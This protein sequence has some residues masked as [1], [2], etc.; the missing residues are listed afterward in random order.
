[1]QQFLFAHTT[2][3]DANELVDTCLR[4][5]GK[6]PDEATLG[7]IYASDALARELASIVARLRAKTG[8]THW[9]GSVGIA[10]NVTGHEYYD[11]PALAI[12][13]ADFPADSFTLLP[14]IAHEHALPTNTQQAHF[15]IL[16][17]DPE[18]PLTPQ[19]IS[20]LGEATGAFLVGGITSAQSE[21]LQV[22][23]T[24]THGGISGVLFNAS[25]P[26]LTRH[27]QGCTPIGPLHTITQGER[28]LVAQLD[29]RAALDVFNEDIG[30]VLAKDLQRVAGYIF[31]GLPIPD[32]DTGDYMVRNIIGVDI[33]QKLLAIGDRMEEGSQLMFCRRDGNS[34]NQDMRRML[35]EIKQA[36]DGK[37]P[38]GGLYFSCLGR[39]RNQFGENSE[40]MKI[41]AEHLGEFP[42]IGFFA[43]GE[44]FHG[45]LYGYTGVLSVFF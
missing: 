4:Q 9:V 27:T 23:D 39:G 25:V 44:I 33:N 19:L 38:K 7:F 14:S 20:S 35:D 31:A 21:N 8:V 26:V 22:L 32:C 30:E 41:I 43:N 12:L 40:E 6:I 36:L 2:G 17:G 34:A 29:G 10:I 13:I 11:Q 28:N 24:P 18:N 3:T 16:H 37:T 42:L 1:M 5:I 45:R 15:G